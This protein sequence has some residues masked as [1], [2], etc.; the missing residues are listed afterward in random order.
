MKLR[1]NTPLLACSLVAASGLFMTACGQEDKKDDK[2]VEEEEDPDETVEVDLAPLES[3]IADLEAQ[4]AALQELLEDTTNADLIASLNDDIETLE[5][6]IDE[7][8]APKCGDAGGTCEN[9]ENAV[10]AMK[11]VLDAVCDHLFDCC[12]PSEVMFGAGFNVTTADQCK[13]VVTARAERGEWILADD[14]DFDIDLSFSFP[15]LPSLASGLERGTVELDTDKIEACAAALSGLECQDRDEDEDEE[16]YSCGVEEEDMSCYGSFSV[17]T[18][19]RDE[20]CDENYDGWVSDCEAGLYC[21][22]GTC[23][24][25]PQ[26]GEDCSGDW[27]CEEDNSYCHPVTHVCTA[28]GQAGDSCSYYDPTKLMNYE[29]VTVDRCGYGTVCSV[30]TDECVSVCDVGANCQEDDNCL[31]DQFCDDSAFEGY[32]Y[33]EYSYPGENYPYL[34]SISGQCAADFAAEADCERDA[35]CL[36]NYC[37]D[38]SCAPVVPSECDEHADCE[39]DEFCYGSVCEPKLATDGYCNSDDDWCASGMCISYQCR[40]AVESGGDCYGSNSDMNALLDAS[41]VCPTGEVCTSNNVCTAILTTGGDCEGTGSG[42][43]DDIVCGPQGYCAD[44]GLCA[45]FTPVGGACNFESSSC[46]S[47]SFC[48]PTDLPD[49]DAGICTA[50]VAPGELCDGSVLYYADQCEDGSECEEDDFGLYRC[51]AIESEGETCPLRYWD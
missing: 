31:S 13:A 5:D 48:L 41:R 6:L 17:G 9:V 32:L 4:L 39:S 36:S 1:I 20:P 7:L 43:S 3:Q 26:L 42:A 30:M 2:Q 49:S 28:F 22:G 21:D 8:T 16:E 15:H 11:P 25:G 29:N 47:S 51:P 37:D 34:G 40:E 33:G 45:P 38:G 18:R 19:G 27:G 24:A 44:S 14:Y 35:Q 23:V 50:R 46:D 12:T 10:M